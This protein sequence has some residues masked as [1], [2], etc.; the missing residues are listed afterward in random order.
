MTRTL[1]SSTPRSRPSNSAAPSA[2][3]TI[4]AQSVARMSAARA[5]PR[6]VG[7][8]PTMAAPASAAPFSQ[9]RYSAP[10]GRSTPTWGL[11]SPKSERARAPRVA[12][13]CTASRQVQRPSPSMTPVRSS[14][15]RATSMAATVVTGVPSPGP[16]APGCGRW[17]RWWRRRRDAWCGAARSRT[18]AA[19]LP[20]RRSHRWRAPTA[21][22]ARPGW[23][24]RPERQRLD[25]VGGAADAA[26]DVDLGLPVHG[27]DDLGQDVRRRPA[28]RRAVGR[29]GWT[30]RWRPRRHRCSARRRRRVGRP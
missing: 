8:M 29:R 2:S 11:A 24:L 7:L 10:L 5:S 22:V 3:V 23:L 26:V 14:S 20:R 18:S 6:R 15:A 12:P 28:R 30:P 17:R 16:G 4:M 21:T 9:K 19:V 27:V 25:H 13:S 1:S